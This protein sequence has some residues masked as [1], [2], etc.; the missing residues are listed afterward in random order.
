MAN[1][2]KEVMNLISRFDAAQEAFAAN[3]AELKSLQKKHK[4]ELKAAKADAKRYRVEV[5]ALKAEMAILKMAAPAKKATPA[6]RGPGRPKKAA[7]TTANAPAERS[8]GRPKRSAT[9][10]VAAKRTA[11]RPKK[12][13]ATKPA[14]KP[15]TGA[16]KRPGRPRTKPVVPQSVLQ[17]IP[18]VGPAM[19]KRFEEAGV[20]T[21]AAFAKLSNAK[22]QPIL[23][24]CGPRYRNAD[25]VKMQGYR[26]AAA[27]VKK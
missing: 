5:E 18:G 14:T 17:T 12:S 10:A 20:K 21:V 16:A 23:E 26:D 1:L 3:S 7:T 19:A 24:T 15:A 22:M 2:K 8:P 11:G 4:K 13:T 9:A 27:S 25:A 6:K